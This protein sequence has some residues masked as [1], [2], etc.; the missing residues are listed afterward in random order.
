[1]MMVVMVVMVA[2]GRHHDD[3]RPVIAV[4]MVMM[5]VAVVVMMVVVVIELRHLDVVFLDVVFT[6]FTGPGPRSQPDLEGVRDRLKEVGV[7]VH[8]EGVRRTSG[9]RP[10][11]AL[12]ARY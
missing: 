3:P 8:L 11:P 5:V 4:V 9:L 6:G 10:E 1:M 12:P 2:A 7:G